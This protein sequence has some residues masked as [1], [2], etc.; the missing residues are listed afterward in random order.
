MSSIRHLE[1]VSKIIRLF[2]E[3]QQQYNIY[4]LVKH[5]PDDHLP[6]YEVEHVFTGPYTSWIQ[7]LRN[8]AI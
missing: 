8:T 6:D 5:I 3:S 4:D 7:G 2:M 1:S